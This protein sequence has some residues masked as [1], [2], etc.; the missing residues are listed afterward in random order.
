[1]VAPNVFIAPIAD[2]DTTGPLDFGLGI[3]RLVQQRKLCPPVISHAKVIY[4]NWNDVDLY[5]NSCYSV[6]IALNMELRER[7][8]SL[9]AKWLLPNHGGLT[10]E[11]YI[12][13]IGLQ[14][15]LLDTTHAERYSP[16]YL[17]AVM[18]WVSC[19]STFLDMVNQQTDAA[20][21][22]LVIWVCIKLAGSLTAT[23]LRARS[24]SEDDPRFR[25]V[26][27][28]MSKYPETREWSGL[29][30]VVKRFQW[31]EHCLAFWYKVWKMVVESDTVARNGYTA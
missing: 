18:R 7:G 13:L 11:D 30:K 10:M 25:L 6:E 5:K 17:T 12:L 22:D 20:T 16:F 31:R 15:T 28:M 8:W 23:F 21:A 29:E 26:I 27:K 9:L 2:Y 1:M 3:A 19:C 14:Q 24:D 4:D